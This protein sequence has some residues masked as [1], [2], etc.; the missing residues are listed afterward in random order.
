MLKVTEVGTPTALNKGKPVV[1]DVPTAKKLLGWQEVEGDQAW[2]FKD[3]EGNRIACTN[4]LNNRPLDM[5]KVRMLTQE[6]LQKRWKVNGEPIILGVSGII[7]NGQHTLISTVLAEQLRTSEEQGEH[8][9]LIHDSPISIQKFV[10]AGIEETDDVVNTM[11]T[12]KPRTLSDMVYRSEYFTTTQDLGKKKKLSS[13]ADGAIKFLWLRTGA[14]S[15]PYSPLRTASESL[16]WL[17]NH[18]RLI[19]VVKH[20]YEESQ[21]SKNLQKLL[22]LSKLTGLVY[23]FAACKSSWT[24]YENTRSEQDMDLSMQD[25]AEEFVI[26]LASGDPAVTEV[27]HAFAALVHPETGVD[28]GSTEHKIAILIK[29]WQRFS[30][31]AKITAASV[32]VEH[33][34]DSEDGYLTQVEYPMVGGIDRGP[35]GDGTTPDMPEP[36]DETPEEKPKKS[37]KSPPAEK[38]DTPQESE[39]DP[40]EDEINRRKEEER[41]KRVERLLKNR[42]KRKAEPDAGTETETSA[43]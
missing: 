32:K 26:M 23:L 31:G 39:E 29:A 43:E 6:I 27:F 28:M 21:A 41:K 22:P 10:N 42:E 38:Q 1:I 16:N 5:G 37:P 4:N 30:S 12:C 9:K 20:V 19:D 13:L 33:L 17:D 24:D 34:V 25:K 8:W 7:L 18:R 35:M 40:D 11:D 14:S 3:H 15:D 2:L 36:E